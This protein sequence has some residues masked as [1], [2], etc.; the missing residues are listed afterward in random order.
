MMKPDLFD[1]HTLT[2][3]D[4]VNLLRRRW[5][6]M[7]VVFMMVLLGAWG[8]LQVFFTDLYETQASLLVKVG[9]ENVEVPVT[10]QKGQV[11]SQGVRIADINSEVQ[12]LSSPAI[13]EAV[14]DH[15][16]PAT[17]RNVL[18]EPTSIWG[19]PKYY[20]KRTAREVKAL[21]KE[22]LIAVNLKKRLEE[23]DEIVLA[24]ADG[25]KVEPVK[26][27]DVLILKMR[28]PS[29][30]LAVDVANQILKE[31]M[32]RRAVIRQM[33]AG[34]DFFAKQLA[35]NE[36]RLSALMTKRAELRDQWQI[37]SPGE[38]RSLLLKQ[39]ADIDS[40][41]I[42][43]GSDIAKLE[44]QRSVL[45]DR[46]R[47][48]PERLEK[49]VVESRNPS[50]QSIKERITALEVERA[51]IQGRY[52]PDSEV[53]KKVDAE[54]AEL[55]SI[56]SRESMTV[57]STQTS[58][59]NPIIRE[60]SKE[61]QEYEAMIAGLQ[62]RNTR[63]AVPSARIQDSLRQINNGTDALEV[64]ER[65]HGVTERNYLM[66]QSKLEEARISEELDARRVTNVALIAQPSTPF[67]PVYPRKLFT[68]LVTL[69]A[70]LLLAIAFA[71]LIESMDDRIRSHR[72]LEQ[73]S[74]LPYLGTFRFQV[75]TI[76]NIDENGKRRKRHRRKTLVFSGPADSE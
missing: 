49:E 54:L 26:D 72:D 18:K 44:N 6:L 19:Y 22:F 4:V 46:M 51:K 53:V 20:L 59:S 17:F 23:R 76:K 60:F 75:E 27:S 37:T 32:A 13:V 33:P 50:I 8:T 62:S 42:V 24:V 61:A 34:S 64:V 48:A 7:V 66:Y 14:V 15:F 3:T 12:M 28:L 25:V 1:T 71:A 43:A 5:L 2:W 9:R 21:Y 67:E 11:F 39:A 41:L 74:E 58:E 36:Q 45:L 40:A 47:N 55:D 31:Y 69:P 52:T 63:L 73:V 56:L 38:Q 10:V 57:R 65:D 35:A 30:E 68:M 16:G 70:A 29:G